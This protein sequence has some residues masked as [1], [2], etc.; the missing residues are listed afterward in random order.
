MKKPYLILSAMITMLL[1]A[2]SAMAFTAPA[3][4]DFMYDLYRIGVEEILQGPIGFL[5]AIL[6]CVAS[7]I[8]AIRQMI[9]PAV[10]TFLA[11]VFLLK[12]D[13]MITGLGA[14]IM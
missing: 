4:G 6:A 9:L 5:G 3:E 2:A 7:A 10:G 11:G 14:L 8:M 1:I 12:S 13:A